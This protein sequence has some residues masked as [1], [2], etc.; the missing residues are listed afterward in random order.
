[1]RSLIISVLLTLFCSFR[2]SEADLLSDPEPA[3]SPSPQKCRA[4][5]GKPDWPSDAEWA[6]L[7]RAVGG[8]LLKPQPPAAACHRSWAGH[9]FAA[10]EELREGWKN[11][12]W[13]TEHPTSNFW[14]NYNNYSCLP[15]SSGSCTTN[16]YPVY[17]VNAKQAGDVKAAIDF[18]RNKNI[19]LN[20]KSTGH[21]FLGRY[22]L[23]TLLPCI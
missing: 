2:Y 22:A 1:M 9:S 5:P 17:V 19:R 13:H 12:D 21:D 14:Q 18:A 4:V 7:N 3:Q 11:S 8:R 16:G 15:H 20:I 6:E 23:E 10:C